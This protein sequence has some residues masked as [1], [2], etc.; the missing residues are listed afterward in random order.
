MQWMKQKNEM[1]LEYSDNFVIQITAHTAFIS[2]VCYRLHCCLIIFQAV[3]VGNSGNT[4]IYNI[5]DVE[6]NAVYKL[7]LVRNDF[8]DEIIYHAVV[9]TIRVCIATPENMRKL[10]LKIINFSS[11]LII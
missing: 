9:F 3:L 7:S 4:I 1:Q 2:T 10:V 6:T 8:S 5:H 11:Y